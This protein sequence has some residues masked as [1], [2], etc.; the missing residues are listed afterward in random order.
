MAEAD[1][2]G[3]RRILTKKQGTEEKETMSHPKER[4]HPDQCPIN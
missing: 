2:D 4:S 3:I 1:T